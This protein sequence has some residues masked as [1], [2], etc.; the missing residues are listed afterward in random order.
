LHLF[1]FILQILRRGN[2]L[3]WEV[4]RKG[5]RRRTGIRSSEKD[6]LKIQL[7]EGTGNW[8]E[9][10]VEVSNKRSSSINEGKYA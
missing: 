9:G 3:G 6:H 2:V 7:P 8:Q 1:T 10:V 5:M 4:W